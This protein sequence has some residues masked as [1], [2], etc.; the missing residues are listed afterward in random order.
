MA[1]PT[2]EKD[3]GVRVLGQVFGALAI[4]TVS[5]IAATVMLSRYEVQTPL[6]RGLAVALAVFGFVTWIASTVIAVRAQDEFTQRIHLIALAAAFSVSGTFVFAADYLQRAH[7]ID[8][9][10][11]MTIWLVMIVTWWLAILVTARLYR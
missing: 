2:D 7:F 8:H 11:L 4:W 3:S 6:L 5:V 9:I 1:Q 10:S